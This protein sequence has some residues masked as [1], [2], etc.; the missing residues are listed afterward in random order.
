[1]TVTQLTRGD[2]SRDGDLG[3]TGDLGRAGDEGLVGTAPFLRDR[4]ARQR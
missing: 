1:M 3:R 4:S 2:L